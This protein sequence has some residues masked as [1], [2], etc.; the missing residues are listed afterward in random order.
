MVD[1]TSTKVPHNDFNFHE[2]HNCL[3]LLT[4]AS[5]WTSA[6]YVVPPRIYH[7]RVG[8]TWFHR[9]FYHLHVGPNNSLTTIGE[10]WTALEGHSMSQAES[11]L[12]VT[13]KSR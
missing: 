4:G 2:Y 7:L 3:L 11:Q 12:N 10:F 6:F 8:S 13:R 1:E 5:G 9:E